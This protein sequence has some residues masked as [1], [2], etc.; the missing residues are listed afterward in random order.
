MIDLNYIKENPEKFS[1]L[2]E[3]RNMIISVDDI[4]NLERKKKNYNI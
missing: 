4:L 1:K 2:M 3:N